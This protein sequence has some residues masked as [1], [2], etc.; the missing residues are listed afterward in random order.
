MKKQKFKIILVVLLSGLS[1][2]C[3]SKPSTAGLE[4]V[5]TASWQS[6]RRHFISPDG[7]VKIPEERGGTISEGQAYALLRALWAGDEITFA[8]VYGWTHRHLSR[9]V[10]YSDSLLAW[11]WGRLPDGSWGL[12]DANS[13]T[14]ADLDYALALVLAH[15]KGWRAPAGLPDYLEESRLVQAAVLAKEVVRLPDGQLLLTPGNWHE[16][17]PPYLVNPSYFSPAAYRLFAQAGPKPEGSSGKVINPPL[18]PFFK[19]GNKGP[20]GQSPPLEKGALGGFKIFSASYVNNGPLLNLALIPLMGEDRGGREAAAAAAPWRD[21][22][23]A[24]YLFL[25]KVSE[26]LGDQKGVGLFP[27]WCRVDAAGGV[28]PAPGKDTRF[29]WEAV[30]VPFRVALDALWF[31]DPQAV[32]LLKDKFLPFFKGQWQARRRL[33]AVYSYNG[34]PAVDYESPVLYAGVLAGAIAAGDRHFARQMAEKILS[35]YRE[36]GNQAYFEAPDNYYANNWAWLGLALYAGW[37]KP[38]N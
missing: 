36:D 3:Q 37:V 8:R 10:K 38:V 27:D 22:H 5:L 30:R 14:D 16:S 26:R 28:S 23:Q 25:I 1:L 33:A 18:P 21:L 20:A 9:A 6:Y 11:R 29:G 15:H 35:F 7:Q 34:A 17:A 31:K 4:K 24:T 2:A 19:G 13:A 32:R 12:L